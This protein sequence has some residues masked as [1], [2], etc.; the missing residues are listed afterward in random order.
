MIPKYTYSEFKQKLKTNPK[1]IARSL[2]ILLDGIPAVKLLDSEKLSISV[3]VNQLAFARSGGLPW[4]L[5]SHE[6]V[7]AILLVTRYAP[8]IY[9]YYVQKHTTPK[10][11]S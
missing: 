8:A 1:W 9:K 10:A 6:G 11:T 7:D 2:R 3:M 5:D 4:T